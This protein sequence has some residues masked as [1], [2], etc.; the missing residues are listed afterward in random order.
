MAAQAQSDN[1][2]SFLKSYYVMK[3]ISSVKIL[4]V[5]L[6]ILFGYTELTIDTQI[7]IIVN[8]L[9]IT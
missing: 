7:I 5:M 8:I 4:S 3:L 6:S 9:I 2:Y 1:M